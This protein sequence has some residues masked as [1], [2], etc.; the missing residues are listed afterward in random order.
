MSRAKLGLALIL[1]LATGCAQRGL[2]LLSEGELPE[3]I[4]GPPQPAPE[5]EE[6]PA[7]GTIFLV[8]KGHLV[9]ARE[10]LQP[11]ADSL[12][13]ALLVA[14]FPPG[15]QDTRS[16]SEIPDG[17]RLNGVEVTGGLATVDVSG[18]FEQ[19]APPRSQALRIAQVVYTLT[20]P[21]TGIGGVRF[22]IDGVPQEAIGGEQLGTIPGPVTRGDYERFRPRGENR[23]EADA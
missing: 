18:D 17:T 8:E 3:E 21:E 6:I 10:T 11:V 1:L 23:D 16:S 19:A 9:P 15:P 12:A 20:E 4:Y 22:Q 14:L 13:E 7:N 2:T 5:S